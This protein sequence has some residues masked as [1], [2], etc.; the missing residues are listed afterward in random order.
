MKALIDA[1]IRPQFPEASDVLAVLDAQEARDGS[2]EL[3]DCPRT[4][5]GQLREWSNGRY[6]LIETE[7]R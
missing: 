5:L 2:T 7:R 1:L 6:T 3:P 4:N